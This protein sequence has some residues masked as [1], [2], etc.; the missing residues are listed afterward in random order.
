L[1]LSKH[2]FFAFLQQANNYTGYQQYCDIK[3][4]HLLSVADPSPK[5][6]ALFLEAGSG[7]ALKS[8]YRSFRGSKWSRG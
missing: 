5:G 3:Y 7:S 6:Y 8:K 2:A 4:A 1:N